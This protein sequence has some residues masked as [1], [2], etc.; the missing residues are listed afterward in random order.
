MGQGTEAR[1]L[2]SRLAVIIE[3]NEWSVLQGTDG[4]CFLSILLV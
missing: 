3:K 2:A 4:P 1:W